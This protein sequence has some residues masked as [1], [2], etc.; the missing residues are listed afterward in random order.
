MRG[1]PRIQSFRACEG[2]AFIAPFI[3]PRRQF[4]SRAYERVEVRCGSAGSVTID[5]RNI[6]NH[7]PQ[8]PLFVHLPPF[9]SNDGVPAPLP[10]FLADKP[11]ASIN[12]RWASPYGA[13]CAGHDSDA[14]T[15]QWPTPIHDTS[16]AYSW[17]V[18]NLAPEGQQRRDIYVYG[19]HLGGSLATSLSLTEAHPHMRIAVR[20]VI[21]YNGVY[22][23]T[24]F[25]PDHQTNRPSKRAKNPGPRRRQ[26]EGSHFYRLQELL[27]YLFRSPVDMFD[28]FVSPSLFFHNPGLLVPE[29]YVMSAAETA[30]LEALVNPES[31]MAEHVKVPRKSHLV[32]PPRQ[33]TQKIP[34]ALFLY[35]SP[36]VP[37]SQ[38][39][40]RR[41]A[42][43]R[44]N[45]MESQAVEIVELMRRSI[46]KVE[47]KEREKWDD[48]LDMWEHEGERR[49]Q[50]RSVGE[51][52]SSLELNAKG[53][54]R[55]EEWLSGRLRTS[56]RGGGEEEEEE[57]KGGA[58]IGMT[59]T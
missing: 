3:R 41:L 47:L 58:L 20:G 25:L 34:E 37:P 11:V 26:V 31:I 23:W 55:V 54:A 28:P 50:V 24:M 21:S 42:I 52:M 53:E 51:E 39:G 36:V 30:A 40:R 46:E 22:N 45:T 43:G 18:E 13:A 2:L 4:S 33:S 5:L 29:S 6:A 27:P 12:Y 35:D 19:S 59:S 32:F 38:P 8:S 17:L 49:V 10:D 57:E 14:V 1:C 44:G 16:F 56:T 15:S 9:P 48:D 7:S